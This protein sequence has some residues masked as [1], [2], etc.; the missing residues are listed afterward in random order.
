MQT[1]EI[2]VESPQRPFEETF[3]L[4]QPLGASP[5][6]VHFQLKTLK[7]FKVHH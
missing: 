3:G 1:E 6:Q 4:W 2:E 7:M 5:V